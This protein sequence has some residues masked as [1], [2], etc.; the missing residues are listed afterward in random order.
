MKSHAIDD[1]LK[2]CKFLETRN[3]VFWRSHTYASREH[4]MDNFKSMIPYFDL[5]YNFKAP[6]ST[7][8]WF[9]CFNMCR[10]RPAVCVLQLQ[11]L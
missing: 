10:S 6:K 11:G 7:E 4:K 8:F 9:T 3:Q 2:T 5:I 1:D